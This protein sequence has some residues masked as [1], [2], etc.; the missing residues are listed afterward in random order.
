MLT[1]TV[2]LK[3]IAE[4]PTLCLSPFRY[5]GICYKCNTW[6]WAKDSRALSCK[7]VIR[8]DAQ[9]LLDLKGHL[10]KQIREIDNELED[11][12]RRLS[13]SEF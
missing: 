10:L 2:S 7:P 1:R 9:V 6:K 12:E 4:S 5:F 11:V 3:E 8:K 13:E